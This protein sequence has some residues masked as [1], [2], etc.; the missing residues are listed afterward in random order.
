LPVG[1]GLASLALARFSLPLEAKTDLKERY[2]FPS[3]AN[4]K[5]A[6]PLARD[7]DVAVQRAQFDLPNMTASSIDLFRDQGR[8][9]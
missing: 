9:L 7:D 8:A 3:V 4:L 5:T 6:S 2:S 1:I